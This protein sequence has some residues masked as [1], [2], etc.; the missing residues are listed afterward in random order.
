MQP[1]VVERYFFF[2]LLFAIF[3]LTFLIFRPFW[4]V[5]VLGASFSII[6]YPIYAWFKKKRF[7]NGMA[8][9]FT[10]IF[11]VIVL[12]VPLFLLGTIVF[13]QSQD[14]F[15]NA[16]SSGNVLPYINSVGTQINHFLPKGVHFNMQE[17]ISGFISF[18]A[19][20]I[21]SILS[22]TVSTLF[23]F[24][25]LLLTI[26][27]LLKD[28]DNWKET[29]LRLSPL[30]GTADEKIISRL[31]KT[32]NGVVKGYLLIALIQGTLMGIGLAIFRVPNPAI[33]GTV[34]GIASII[35]PL[36]TA[37]VSVPA[38]IFLFLTGHTALALGLLAWAILIVGTGDNVLN[39]YIIGSK[40]NIPPFLILFSVLGGIALLGPVGLLIGPL[41][42]SM[43][44]AL[45][46]IYKT[47]FK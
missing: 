20:N 18:L 15:Q 43:L 28:G 33:W 36:G 34:A 2:G 32:V 30:S 10:I 5:L 3:I 17:K 24:L 19:N 9:L 4:I 16:V 45:T 25:L 13:N 14:L 22:A 46:D 29:L 39:P 44:Y 11:F 7:S 23:S 27:Y 38:V 1:K 26:F 37:V 31:T 47:E 40:L 41:T 6:L 21:A 42:V 35:P 12:C 8:S